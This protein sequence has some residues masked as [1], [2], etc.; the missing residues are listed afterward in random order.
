MVKPKA[1][2]TAAKHKQ[3]T[4]R[5]VQTR[6]DAVLRRL[7]LF[8]PFGDRRQRDVLRLDR[9]LEDIDAPMVLFGLLLYVRQRNRGDKQQFSLVGRRWSFV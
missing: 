3:N 1:A 6:R 4:A 5:L 8:L 7:L 9:L 2:A